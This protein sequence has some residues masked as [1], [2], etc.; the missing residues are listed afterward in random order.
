MTSYD[1]NPG[2]E[3]ELKLIHRYGIYFVFQSGEDLLVSNV[4]S[5]AV[6]ALFFF[7]N[8]R[9]QQTGWLIQK[10]NH[11]TIVPSNPHNYED[12]N[13]SGGSM[14]ALAVLFANYNRP[15]YL[16]TTGIASI[17]IGGAYLYIYFKSI[18]ELNRHGIKIGKQESVPVMWVAKTEKKYFLSSL[19]PTKL[20]VAVLF[21]LSVI[22]VAVTSSLILFIVALIVLLITECMIFKYQMNVSIPF[23]SG[24]I[25]KGHF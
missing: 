18:R 11:A 5:F 20:V 16:W 14:S 15:F 17:L 1:Y 9:N 8:W 6:S 4:I 7:R 12:V 24:Y 22:T 3:Y 19:T 10:E 13:I 23:T 21:N 25:R 2:N